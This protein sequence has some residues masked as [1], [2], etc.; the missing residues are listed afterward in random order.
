M[1]YSKPD[2]ADGQTTRM[3]GLVEDT[4]SHGVGHPNKEWLEYHPDK[5][6]LGTHGCCIMGCCGQPDEVDNSS[7]NAKGNSLKNED[8]NSGYNMNG[9][10][11]VSP[12][13]QFSDKLIGTL[14][15]Y[16]KCE[17]NIAVKSMDWALAMWD[18]DQELRNRIKYQDG[19]TGEVAGLEW[20]REQLHEIL[21]HSGV[22]LD[23]IQ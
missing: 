14:Y 9:Q 2:W 5:P 20:A 8:K 7:I 6:E 23:D 3:S 19:A 12:T 1:K 4:C 22:S 13:I 18:L 10:Q 21:A 16:D 15:F 17:M 11:V